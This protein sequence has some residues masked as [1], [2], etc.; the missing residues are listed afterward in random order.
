MIRRGWSDKEI[1]GLLGGQCVKSL[2]NTGL[3]ATSE[4]MLRILDKVDDV[5][6]KLQHERPA[7]EIY[8]HRMD[9]PKKAE[10]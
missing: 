5:A 6:D 2:A 1:I 4:N 7:T 3:T 9:I 8:K 10:L